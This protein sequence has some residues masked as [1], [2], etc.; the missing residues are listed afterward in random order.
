VQFKT[1]FWLPRSKNPPNSLCKEGAG[2]IFPTG[3]NRKRYPI[4][5]IETIFPRPEM[6]EMDY[7]PAIG[8]PKNERQQ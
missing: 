8:R 3:T 1:E 6:A 7:L 4:F 5:K 2:G